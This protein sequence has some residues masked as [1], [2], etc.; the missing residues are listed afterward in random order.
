MYL[1]K[2]KVIRGYSVYKRPVFYNYV[3]TIEICCL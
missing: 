3:A 2:P 1:T